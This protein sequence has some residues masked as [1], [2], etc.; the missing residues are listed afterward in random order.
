[1]NATILEFTIEDYP[2]ALALWKATEGMGLSSADEPGPIAA[3][4]ARNPGSSF[5]AR[6]NGELVGTILAGH[7][8]R[9]GFIHHLAVR[10]DYRRIGLGNELT[11]CALAA[12]RAQGMQK[13]HLFV[14]AGNQAGRSFWK[15]LGWKER[16]DIVTMSKE[17]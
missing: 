7:D 10:S 11:E 5:V 4:L 9:R 17:I 8:G 6:V 1:M 15:R 16:G 2:E 12:L 13:C 14:I 3:Y